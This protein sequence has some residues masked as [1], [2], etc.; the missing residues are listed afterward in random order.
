M[1]SSLD[2]PLSAQISYQRPLPED[3]F[4]G[5]VGAVDKLFGDDHNAFERLY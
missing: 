5:S 3:F 4:L 1:K 2:I